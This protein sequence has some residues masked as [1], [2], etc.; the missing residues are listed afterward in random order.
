LKQV[1]AGT[2]AW[3][4]PGLTGKSVALVGTAGVQLSFN[5]VG[6]GKLAHSIIEFFNKA[7]A[8]NPKL[9]KLLGGLSLTSRMLFADYMMTNVVPEQA[10][11]ENLAHWIDS[12]VGHATG[13]PTA[14]VKTAANEIGLSDY[15]PEELKDARKGVSLLPEYK[16]PIELNKALAAI[17]IGA[18]IEELPEGYAK[19]WLINGLKTYATPYSAATQIIANILIAFI[20]AGKYVAPLIVKAMGTTKA[21]LPNDNDKAV[22]APPPEPATRTEPDANAQQDQTDLSTPEQPAPAP[23]PA[24]PA[25][26]PAAPASSP[27]ASNKKAKKP[28]VTNPDLDA[29]TLQRESVRESLKRRVEKLMRS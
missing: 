19:E 4:A 26:A 12:V 16:D 14:A 22:I 23:A 11:S 25:S 13:I 3:F 24:A 6:K 8:N 18:S 21:K 17:S 27:E 9:I 2:V 15:T 29:F 10:S 5:L 1:C 20:D 28:A 7:W